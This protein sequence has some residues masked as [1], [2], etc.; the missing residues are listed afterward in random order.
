MLILTC[1]L[2]GEA[3]S[4]SNL[5]GIER[6]C[7][8]SVKLSLYQFFT[9]ADLHELSSV[10]RGC[11]LDPPNSS[12]SIRLLINHPYFSEASSVLLED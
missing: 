6:G 12:M 10:T 8:V 9:C 1:M 11:T 4:L 5:L 3:F 2:G 7:G